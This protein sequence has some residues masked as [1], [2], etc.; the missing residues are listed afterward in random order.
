[1]RLGFVVTTLLCFAS[2]LVGQ[3]AP[4]TDAAALLQKT[5]NAMLQRVQGAPS[6]HMVLNLA[7]T[8]ADEKKVQQGTYEET[9]LDPQHWKRHLSFDGKETTVLREGDKYWHGT[10]DNTS[11]PS[12]VME[13]V[14]WALPSFP[15]SYA[16]DA[17]VKQS[18][19]AQ[20][21]A[22]K[23]V[24]P[25]P[26]GSPGALSWH[27]LKSGEHLTSCTLGYEVVN[28]RR[29]GQLAKKTVPVEFTTE[30]HG[31]RLEVKATGFQA[32]M[33]EGSEKLTMPASPA[34]LD[35]DA[36]HPYPLIGALLLPDRLFGSSGSGAIG[37][38]TPIQ[39]QSDSSSA[40]HLRGV[41]TFDFTLGTDGVVK[42][43][44]LQ[45]KPSLLAPTAERK[46]LSWRFTPMILDGEPTEMK[47]SD[48]PVY[49]SA[50]D[51]P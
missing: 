7:Y 28:Y 37:P 48:F 5:Q 16:A 21:D 44:T 51:E 10:Q 40:F 24:A 15:P 47:L 32:N 50:K 6:F 43:V 1:M 36:Q 23:I 25:V 11:L 39:M 22:W 13:I 31:A 45:S 41:T 20:R 8:A 2:S 30:D 42:N 35:P 29:L 17:L 49:A 18:N 46:L 14:A 4:P 19:V 34:S 38:G 9:W 3:S 26:K 33:Q 12:L 27:V